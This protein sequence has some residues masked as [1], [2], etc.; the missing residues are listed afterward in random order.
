[1]FRGVMPRRI[2]TMRAKFE[3]K[4]KVMHKILTTDLLD[5]LVRQGYRFCLSRTTFLLGDDD[6]RCVTLL[7]VKDKPFSNHLPGQFDAC[8]EINKEPL[9]MA[10]GADESIVLVDLSEVTIYAY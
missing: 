4:I 2:K 1:M 3:R 6:D 9:Q 7:P 5:S 10:K 8:Y